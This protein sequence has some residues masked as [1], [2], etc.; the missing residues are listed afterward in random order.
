MQ[1][2]SLG[3]VNTAKLV[4]QIVTAPNLFNLLGVQPMMGRAFLP[5]D[6]HGGNTAV[7]V[8]SH[9]AWQ[10]L[11]HGD[12]QILGRSVAVNGIPTTVIGI[13]P[14]GFSFPANAG[15]TV[16]WTPLPLDDKLLQ[17]RNSSSLT[18]IGRLRTG[19]TVAQATQEMNGIHQQLVHEHPKEED[20]APIHIATY[21]NTITGS[22]RPAILALNS[23][24]IAVWLIACANVAGLLLARANGRRREIA[25]RT[26]LGAQRG[27]L[28]RQLLTEV[29]FSHS[30]VAHSASSS[31]TFRSICCAIT[32]PTPS[33]SAT[34]STSTPASAPFSSSAAASRPSSSVCCRL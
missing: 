34:R 6:A 25:L 24:V 14:A 32:S 15:D 3:G 9:Q 8:L 31:P 17:D 11:Y 5:A 19:V 7:V 27:R 21:A 20:P 23:A 22:I 30:P 10:T 4:P 33:S 13:M 18:V 2:P 26:A 12:P 1:F 28:I 29:S 16:I